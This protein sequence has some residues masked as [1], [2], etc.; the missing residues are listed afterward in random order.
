MPLRTGKTK[1]TVVTRGKP[2][3]GVR[4]AQQI[5][6]YGV[7]SLIAIGDQ[8]YVVSGLDTWKDD[9]A[10]T[11]TEDRLV[12]QLKGVN[13]LR[14]PP[15]DTPESG[16]GIKVRRFPEMYSCKE[17]GDLKKYRFFGSTDGSCNACAKRLVPSRF[18]S[19]CEYGHLDEFPFFEWLHKK[20]E[21]SGADRHEM[22][23]RSSG[24]SG[25]L[26]SIE[27]HC[28]CGVT[29]KSME[30][31][32]SKGALR[33]L[34]IKCHGRRPW[35]GT[36]TDGVDQPDCQGIRRGMQRG[37]SAA[38]FPVVRS[39]ITIPPFSTRVAE[40]VS[41]YISGWAL[42]AVPD[43]LIRA[44][45]QAQ[46]LDHGGVSLDDI[47]RYVHLYRAERRRLLDSPE[48]GE[49]E[50]ELLPTQDPLRPDEYDQLLRTTPDD[51]DNVNFV[52]VPPPAD[53]GLPAPAGVD[54]VMLVKRLREVRALTSFTRVDLPSES[55]GR[56]ASITL[57]RDWR[58]AVEVI[59]EGV[60]LSLDRAEVT[61][62]EGQASVRSR[63]DTLRARHQE[64]LDR[65]F[66]ALPHVPSSPVTAR[67]VL[68]HT[69][70]HALINEWSL[71]AGYPSSAL[72]ERLYVDDGPAGM[73]GILVYTATS[74][75]AGSLGGLVAQ[76]ETRH[77]R[78]TFA[79]AL[80]RVSWCSADP[81]CM[82]SEASGTDSLNLAA[83]HACVLLPEVSCELS[84]SFL[85]RAMLIGS[86]DSAAT[87]MFHG[88]Q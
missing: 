52:C 74:D 78:R 27:I 12:A 73:S 56:K 44:M 14:W 17:C 59:G 11:I 57:H 66:R 19:A 85:D 38:W 36:P 64:V 62:W 24:E 18:V 87:G 40:L 22:T 53:T 80:E 51:A 2:I 21:P 6:T 76:G 48:A 1:S 8:S 7:G 61:A 16:F 43:D 13:S 45:A 68:L 81:L 49:D 86:P 71:D 72:R 63:A 37:S 47:V 55:P 31:A 83:C 39:A 3:G 33:E 28:T 84:N 29:A 58:P 65:R 79:T 60:F 77:L 9:P 46:G 32:L 4:R 54:K 15:A 69:L 34:G 23:L 30:G 35:L 41:R 10:L 70:A 42:D 20:V 67:L 25:S 75:S 82:E 26:R 5:T 50:V 88:W